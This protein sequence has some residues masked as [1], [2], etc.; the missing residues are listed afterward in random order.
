MQYVI[1]QLKIVVQRVHSM[2][3]HINVHLLI[4]YCSRYQIALKLDN[5]LETLVLIMALHQAIMV[6]THPQK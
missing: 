3:A 4:G 2:Q 1:P 6:L 5:K